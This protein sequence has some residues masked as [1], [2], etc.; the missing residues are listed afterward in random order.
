MTDRVSLPVLE[1]AGAPLVPCIQ[2]ARCCT[3]VAVGINPPTRPRFATDILWYLYHD[4]V[5]VH[6]DEA[7]EWSV[8]FE[9]RCRHLA[10][11]LLCGIYPERP[12]ICRAFDNTCCE[13]NAPQGGRS[14]GEPQEFVA[15]LES[16]KP[17]LLRRIRRYVAGRAT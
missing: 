7:G 2:C 17:E 9:T 14:F 6:V 15:W 8:V 4:Q 12:H 11:D 3:Y 16:E 13:V 1:S 10:S 5:S